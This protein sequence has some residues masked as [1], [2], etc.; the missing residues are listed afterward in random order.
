MEILNIEDLVEV[1][2]KIDFKN[3][4]RNGFIL[5]PSPNGF[6]IYEMSQDR[7][8]LYVDAERV[9]NHYKKITDEKEST[10]SH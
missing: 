5:L 6:D 4:S 8:Q 7:L 9:Y 1:I 3:V 10:V 2:K